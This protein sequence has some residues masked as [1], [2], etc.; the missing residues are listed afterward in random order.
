[1]A[2]EGRAAKRADRLRQHEERRLQLGDRAVRDTRLAAGLGVLSLMCPFG[3]AVWAMWVA[4]RARKELTRRRLRG[5]P[6]L[7]RLAAATSSVGLALTFY[8]LVFLAIDTFNG[9]AEPGT[10][11]GV[12]GLGIFLAVPTVSLGVWW[13]A[14]DPEQLGDPGPNRQS[15]C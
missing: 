3:L 9:S 6:G 14:K 1:M 10:W 11:V 13:S 5:S 15:P 7:L 2:A 8:V 12:I 4:L